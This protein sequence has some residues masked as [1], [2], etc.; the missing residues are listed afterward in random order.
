[1]KLDRNSNELLQNN[2]CIDT[3]LYTSKICRIGKREKILIRLL[4]WNFL[5]VSSISS[6]RGRNEE[7]KLWTQSPDFDFEESGV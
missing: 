4:R 2:S 5:E 7:Y 3:L 1:M 6:Y